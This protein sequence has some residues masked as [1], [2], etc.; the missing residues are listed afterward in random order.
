M[1]KEQW[2]S[3]EDFCSYYQVEY[4]FISSLYESGLIEITIEEERRF[5][6]IEQI[7]ELE[8]FVHLHYDL[9]INIEGIE[10]IAHLLNRIKEMQNEIAGLKRNKFTFSE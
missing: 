1:D 9:D 6:S 4:S 3:A 8:K 5:I 7:K 2:I 10:A